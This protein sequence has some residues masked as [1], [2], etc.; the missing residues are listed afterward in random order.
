MQQGIEI[1]TKIAI[2][3]QN[4]IYNKEHKVRKNIKRVKQNKAL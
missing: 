2:Y 1:T 4:V 3:M